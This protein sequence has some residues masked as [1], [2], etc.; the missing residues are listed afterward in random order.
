MYNR[1]PSRRVYVNLSVGAVKRLRDAAALHSSQNGT[2]VLV[3]RRQP[4]ADLSNAEIWPYA[5]PTVMH[6]HHYM[7]NVFNFMPHHEFYCGQL[8]AGYGTVPCRGWC[9]ERAAGPG[10]A[11]AAED[12]AARGCR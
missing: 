2:W 10:G 5:L 7:N 8:P 11:G 9:V 12:G 4:L 3:A 1:S 6:P